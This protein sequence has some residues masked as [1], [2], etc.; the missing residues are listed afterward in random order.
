MTE[1]LH[2]RGRV[3]NHINVTSS[4]QFTKY[5]EDVDEAYFNPL[6]DQIKRDIR[7]LSHRSHVDLVHYLSIVAANGAVP[8]RSTQDLLTHTGKGREYGQRH[9]WLQKRIGSC[10]DHEPRAAHCTDRKGQARSYAGCG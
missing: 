8:E 9:V 4:T 6:V 10:L 5:F 3:I 7:D 2:V 1:R